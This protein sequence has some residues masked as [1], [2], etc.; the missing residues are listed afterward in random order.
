M[1]TK[2]LHTVYAGCLSDSDSHMWRK[3]T[4]SKIGGWCPA[5]PREKS[6][7]YIS[8]AANV[9]TLGMVSRSWVLLTQILQC[10]PVNSWARSLANFV[11]FFHSLGCL[12][13]QVSRI[14][15]SKPNILL[16]FVGN[17]GNLKLKIRKR[18]SSKTKHCSLG[19]VG[20]SFVEYN[21]DWGGTPPKHFCYCVRKPSI[22]DSPW[23]C[24]NRIHPQVVNTFKCQGG[25]P[26]R[27]L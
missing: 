10:V 13:L 17:Q 1:N 7:D 8:K 2:W 5:P 9:P 21:M 6:C 15:W 4:E 11:T 12:V 24:V 25:L 3:Q 14:R 27:L 23:E 26:V 18:P 20:A 22:Q 19:P 16:Q